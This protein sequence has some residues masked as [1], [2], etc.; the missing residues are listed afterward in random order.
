MGVTSGAVSFAKLKSPPGGRPFWDLYFYFSGLG[1]IVGQERQA[2]VDAIEGL[3]PRSTCLLRQFL[4]GLLAHHV[5]GVPI[6]PV[7]IGFPSPRFMLPVGHRGATRRLGKVVRRGVCRVACNAPRKPLRD[8]LQQPAVAIRISE[9]SFMVRFA[10]LVL[11]AASLL[12]TSLVLISDSCVVRDR[13]R[14]RI[15]EGTRRGHPVSSQ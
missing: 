11:P 9:A 12:R 5:I 14:A 8:L 4:A 1:E 2:G 3:D 6:W 7:G 15:P 13:G 10:T